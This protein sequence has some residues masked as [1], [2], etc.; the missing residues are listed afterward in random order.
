MKKIDLNGRKIGKLTPIET[1]KYKNKLCWKCLCDCGNEFIGT[2]SQLNSEK[3]KSCG[4]LKNDKFN[5]LVGKKFGK[6]T[7]ISFVKR[8]KYRETIYNC[9][10]DCGNNKNIFQKNLVRNKDANCGCIPINYS[11][12]SR[13]KYGESNKNKLISSYKS[14]AK[15]RDI[16]FTLNKDEM[17]SMFQSNCYYCDIKPST[18]MDT[19]KSYGEYIYNGIDR[20]NNDKN[21]G[22]TFDNTVSCCTK[23]NFIKNKL[24]HDEF[25][26]WIEKVY[27]NLNNN[28]RFRIK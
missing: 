26:D 18:I 12:H 11:L 9:L 6:L 24:N 21:I 7:V 5:E 16:N 10:C 19:K 17:I 13:K 25:I 27:N 2:T 15:H 20:L 22:Y 3:V 23:C 14:N 28:G 1:I 4:C 8:T